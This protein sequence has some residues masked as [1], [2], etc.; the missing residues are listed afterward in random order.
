MPL[1]SHIPIP[2]SS[3]GSETGLEMMEQRLPAVISAEDTRT[4]MTVYPSIEDIEPH[5]LRNKD[6]YANKLS[7][8]YSPVH[9]AEPS[10]LGKVLKKRFRKLFHC[11]FFSSKVSPAGSGRK[12]D[13]V[14]EILPEY[15][16]VLYLLR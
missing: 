5:L 2:A 14:F 7:E 4:H 9:F 16:Q 13:M 8:E 12:E 15:Q 1:P 11:F 6:I 3:E 10:T